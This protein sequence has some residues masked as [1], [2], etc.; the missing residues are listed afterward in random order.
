MTCCTFK[1]TA[2][3]SPLGIEQNRTDKKKKKNRREGNKN[4]ERKHPNPF[5]REEAQNPHTQ[6]NQQ[7]S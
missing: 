2:T 6:T 7:N 3:L 1:T 4:W 5:P